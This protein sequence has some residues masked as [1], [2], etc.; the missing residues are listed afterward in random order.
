MEGAKVKTKGAK[1]GKKGVKGV[2]ERRG[3]ERSLGHKEQKTRRDKRKRAK[4]ET[5]GATKRRERE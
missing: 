3:K 1:D 5:K 4:D 2:E